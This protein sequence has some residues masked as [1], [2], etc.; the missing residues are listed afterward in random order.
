MPLLTLGVHPQLHQGTKLLIYV[1]NMH[2]IFGSYKL[3]CTAA[4]ISFLYNVHLNILQ[5][6]TIL[7][8]LQW[9][10]LF[11][12]PQSV[13]LICSSVVSHVDTSSREVTSYL[14]WR[15]ARSRS[16]FPAV[17][18]WMYS[19]RCELTNILYM[20]IF[21]YWTDTIRCWDSP[22]TSKNSDGELGATG[23]WFCSAVVQFSKPV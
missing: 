14:C 12:S 3:S 2:I 9:G 23:A 15:L 10:F 8:I 13:L 5:N 7:S 20:M 21:T 6:T 17:A 22:R 4:W 19:C 11:V 1:Y 18:G 16:L